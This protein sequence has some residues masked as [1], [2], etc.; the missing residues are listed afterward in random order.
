[1][2]GSI[3]E[4]LGLWSGTAFILLV[5]GVDLSE[6]GGEGGVGVSDTVEDADF[7][8]GVAIVGDE[9]EVV[10]ESSESAD[11]GRASSGT[12]GSGLFLC[13]RS[14]VSSALRNLSCL[15]SASIRKSLS[16]SRNL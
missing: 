14:I 11:C 13:W 4:G 8:G 6:V 3:V 16:S 5:A 10:G 7:V 9:L 15:I 1:M 12:I 2:F